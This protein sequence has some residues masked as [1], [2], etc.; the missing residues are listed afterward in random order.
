[1][2]NAIKYSPP[3]TPISIE[4]LKTDIGIEVRVIDEGIGI[5]PQDLDRV[6]DKF[7]RVSRPEQIHGT[8]LGLAISKGIIE[9]HGG[10]IH[11]ENRPEGGTVMTIRLPG[12]NPK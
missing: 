7:Y 12:E 2:D 4:V 8:G 11:A 6:F 1:M 10:S 5:P 9:A 3:E